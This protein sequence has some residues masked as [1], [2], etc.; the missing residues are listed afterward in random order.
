MSVLV[1]NVRGGRKEGLFAGSYVSRLS[2]SRELLRERGTP[3]QR[4]NNCLDHQQ[5]TAGSLAPDA[6]IRKVPAGQQINGNQLIAAVPSAGSYISC[7]VSV[8]S[9]VLG[10]IC[11]AGNRKCNM[12][13]LSLSLSLPLSLHAS[14]GG[15]VWFCFREDPSCPSSLLC[16]AERAPTSRQKRKCTLVKNKIQRTSS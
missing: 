3:R 9:S 4:L 2:R 11:I 12:S 1:P 10:R 13:A 6:S 7:S 16:W 8:Q 15:Y 5:Q 14:V